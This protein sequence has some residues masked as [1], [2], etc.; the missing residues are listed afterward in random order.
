[1]AWMM[2]RLATLLLLAGSA[3]ACSDGAGNSL[4]A[5]VGG[6]V[7]SEYGRVSR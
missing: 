2:R 6:T 7:R 1:M 4:S 5:G 3:A